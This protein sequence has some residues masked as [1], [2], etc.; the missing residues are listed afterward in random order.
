MGTGGTISGAS[1]YLKERNPNIVIVGVDPAGSVLSGDAPK[2]YRVEGIGEDFVPKTFNRQVVDEMVRVTDEES[3]SMARRLAREEGLLVGGSSG[4]AVAGAIQYARRLE[5]G[6]TVV[7]LLPDTGRNYL[8][9]FFSDQWM[10]EAGIPV[11]EPAKFTAGKVLAAKHGVA[12]LIAIGSR[13]KAIEA[14]ELMENFAISQLPVIDDGK[15][16]G[17]LSEVTLIKHLHDG[18][19]LEQKSVREI[20][21]KPLPAVDE[22]VDVSE[23]YRL[24]MAGYSGVIVTRNGTPQG[25]LTRIDLAHFWARQIKEQARPK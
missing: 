25:F 10:R 21:G 3:F 19:D 23:P 11:G 16:V 18:V 8:T 17:A 9:K 20:M 6:K 15:A 13:N 2:S 12:K 14:M 1:R 7:V 4:T 5:P 24:L 22:K